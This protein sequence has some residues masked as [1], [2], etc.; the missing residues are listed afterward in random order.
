MKVRF[1]RPAGSARTYSYEIQRSV[2]RR[3]WRRWTS[4]ESARYIRI[5]ISGLRAGSGRA[6]IVEAKAFAPAR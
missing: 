6:S 5:Y 4:G 2:G 3:E 1:Y